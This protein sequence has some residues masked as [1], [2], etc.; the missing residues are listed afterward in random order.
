MI[1]FDNFMPVGYQID[2]SVFKNIKDMLSQRDSLISSL[3]GNNV[4][5][6]GFVNNGSGTYSAG[7]IVHN[8]KPYRFISGAV[9]PKLKI[10]RIAHT[11]PD[12]NQQEKPSHYEDVLEFS[13]DAAAEIDFSSLTRYNPYGAIV[14]EVREY[15][16]ALN[17]IPAGWYLCDGTNGTPDRKR[18]VAVGLDTSKVAYNTIG[19]TGGQEQVTLTEAQMP[20]HN[21]NG[22][23]ESPSQTANSGTDVHFTV[24]GYNR[25]NITKTLNISSSGGGQPHD[26]MMP[27]IVAGFIMWKGI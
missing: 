22:T 26:N 17:A 5:L 21:H 3:A 24:Q 2:T 7:F 8:G 10:K 25:K 20:S 15:H 12:E 14:G 4:I 9:K 18:R 6:S 23:V 1:H 16:G 27:F 11:R 13:S 19:K